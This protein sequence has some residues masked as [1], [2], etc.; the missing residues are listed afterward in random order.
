MLMVKSPT[1]IERIQDSGLCQLV[2]QSMARLLADFPEP[3]TPESHGW[4]LILDTA[5]DFWMAAPFHDRFNFLD[6]A[7]HHL[8]EHVTHRGSWLEV[9]VALT[10][11][12]AV[13]VY[14]PAG[15]AAATP[16]LSGLLAVAVPGSA[17][18]G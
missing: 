14:V 8:Y 15:L 11:S 4:F 7:A 9:V 1:E 3:Y 6:I 5:D 10:D 18:E 16:V 2:S 17:H 13:A 12:E